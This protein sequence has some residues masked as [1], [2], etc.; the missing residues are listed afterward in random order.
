MNLLDTLVHQVIGLPLQAPDPPKE[1]KLGREKATRE[2]CETTQDASKYS[3]QLEGLKDPIYRQVAQ[4]MALKL[5]GLHQPTHV[6]IHLLAAIIGVAEG[7][8]LPIPSEMEMLT[9]MHAWC[10][11]YGCGKITNQDVAVWF[12]EMQRVIKWLE[13]DSS[14]S[15]TSMRRNSATGSLHGQETSS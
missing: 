9:K 6:P 4:L 3:I 15:P 13:T 2:Y 10:R 7:V 12:D 14:E 5:F 8:W 1:M 11:V